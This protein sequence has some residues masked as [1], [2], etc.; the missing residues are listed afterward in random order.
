MTK[1]KEKV[2]ICLVGCGAI[3]RKHVAALKRIE[4]AEIVG[5]YDKN[6]E[7][8]LRFG[9]DNDIKVFE[10]CEKMIRQGNPE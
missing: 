6:R 8:A 7:T 5:V 3:S 10:D 2:R 1:S 9:K 4:D